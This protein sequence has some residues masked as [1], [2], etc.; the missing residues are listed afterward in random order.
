MICVD[1]PLWPPPVIAF[2][3][4]SE[5]VIYQNRSRRIPQSGDATLKD[6]LRCRGFEL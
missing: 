5:I 3:T 1:N 4:D 6:V 2:A